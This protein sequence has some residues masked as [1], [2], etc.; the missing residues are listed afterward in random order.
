MKIDTVTL[1]S[2]VTVL[3]KKPGNP[4]HYANYAQANKKIT[5]LKAAGI[6]A[7]LFGYGRPAK[8][9]RIWE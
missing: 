3:A 1:P 4:L 9:I 2:G 6:N 5:E 7:T 8:Y